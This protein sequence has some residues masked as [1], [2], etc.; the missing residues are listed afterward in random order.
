MRYRDKYINGNYFVKLEGSTKTRRTLRVGEEFIPSFPDSIDLKITGKCKFGCPYCHES[1]GP[2]GTHANLE[3]LKEVLS[4]LPEVPIEL[5][6]GGGDVIEC[7]DL[8]MKLT[9][10][11]TERGFKNR[12]T[13]NY[14][15]FSECSDDTNLRTILSRVS[16]VG[17]SIDKYTPEVDK[18]VDNNV[19][20]S[21]VVYHIIPGIFP[22]SD[23]E[24]LL[25]K[26]DRRVLILGYKQWGRASGTPLPPELPEWSRRISE[27]IWNARSKYKSGYVDSILGF[28][29]LAIEQLGLRDCLLDV[30]WK[31]LYQ[32]D[33]FTSSMYI[34]AVSETFAP[35]SRDPNR[36]SWSEMGLLEYFRKYNRS[37]LG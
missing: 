30:E 25:Q 24:P 36:V 7:V 1:S 19:L 2:N 29:N 35:T 10:W 13:L 27:I 5:A 31:K 6:I 34:D 8:F 3:K 20:F 21:E 23:L 12:V 28:D 18:L 15:N 11:T 32:G 16:A 4:S 26:S 9:D 17:V 33:E 37:K 22:L 14:R